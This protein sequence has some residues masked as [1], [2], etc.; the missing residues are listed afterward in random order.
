MN[1]E[2]GQNIFSFHFSPSASLEMWSTRTQL[3]A[4]Y[5]CPQEYNYMDSKRIVTL[6]CG[7]PDKSTETQETV[8]LGLGS[9]LGQEMNQ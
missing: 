5:K 4:S 3:M 1:Y 6:L 8:S 2:V 7:Q 9:N